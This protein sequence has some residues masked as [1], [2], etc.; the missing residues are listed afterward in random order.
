MKFILSF[1]LL[2][3]SLHVFAIDKGIY[4]TDDR[5]NVFE[6][7]QMWQEAARSVAVLVPN[8]QVVPMADEL[9]QSLIQTR[10]HRSVNRVCADENFAEEPAPG[11]CTGFLVADDLM[12]TA[13]HCMRF[14]TSINN[15]RWVFDY[16]YF[17]EGHDINTINN[18]N[19]YRSVEVV[20]RKVDMRKGLEY[21][22][23]RL[24]RPVVGR[25]PLKFRKEG[26][27]SKG[28]PLTVI[29]SPSGLPLKIANSAFVREVK[30][31]TYF[32]T[33]TDTFG[34]NSGSPVFNA[35][36][37]EVEGILVRGDTDYFYDK[38][39]H[40]YRV[41]RCQM[42]ECNGEDVVSIQNVEYLMK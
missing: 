4:G 32:V 10:N 40:C 31:S 23:V 12:L 1:L 36:S 37:G 20:Q 6:A 29:G 24:D 42:N 17:E 38:E 13:S 14:K 2:S 41:Q 9:Q 25:T 3:L 35:D 33:N 28:E 27:I 18:D 39:A 19:V 21:L 7:P 22:L 30:S 11:Q 34:G 5:M 8:Q 26:S 16:G 15:Y